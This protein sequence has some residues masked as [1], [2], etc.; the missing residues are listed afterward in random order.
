MGSNKYN[1]VLM[2]LNE[3]IKTLDEQANQLKD[4]Y[5]YW[6]GARRDDKDPKRTEYSVRVKNR[7]KE[8]VIK[9]VGATVA[10]AVNDAA[11]QIKL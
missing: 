2:D 8:I 7:N 6:V 9:G 5:S 11:K 1:M 3:L 10:A 4:T